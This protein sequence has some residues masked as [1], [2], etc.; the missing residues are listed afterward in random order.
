MARP[1]RVPSIH[2]VHEELRSGCAIDV[3]GTKNHGKNCFLLQNSGKFTVELLGR[4]ST[5]MSLEFDQKSNE[6]VA[7]S[8]T[9]KEIEKVSSYEC[10]RLDVRRFHLHLSVSDCYF[11]IEL[12]GSYVG[13]FVPTGDV[14]KVEAI[15]IKGD[16]IVNIMTIEGFPYLKSELNLWNGWNT[17]CF[18]WTEDTFKH[19]GYPTEAESQTSINGDSSSSLSRS[20]SQSVSTDE[21]TITRIHWKP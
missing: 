11:D 13:C 12:N 14:R 8:R 18:E 9:G 2:P 21:C 15:G 4:S 17:V 16:L 3:H 10:Y 19:F 20:E 6:I 1:V 5:I 7:I